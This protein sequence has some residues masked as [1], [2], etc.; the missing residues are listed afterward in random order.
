MRGKL[1]SLRPMIQDDSD[2]YFKWI[3]NKELVLKNADFKPVSRADHDHWFNTVAEHP[4]VH[5]FSIVE[6]QQNQLIGSC[7]LR[8]INL[9]HKNAELQIRIGEMDY[10]GRGFGTEAVAL[11]VNYG[12]NELN[13]KRIYLHVFCHNTAAIRAYEK[14]QFQ[15]EGV[16]R[17]A[18]F[19]DGRFIDVKVM[20]LLSDVV[21]SA[22]G[23]Y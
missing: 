13:L 22:R 18:A 21:P 11:L 4:N 14:C 10:H 15:S 7:S 23:L 17:Q 6:N 2:R 12:F 19:I 8:N 3:N 5:T 1:V 20:A 9:H 16:L